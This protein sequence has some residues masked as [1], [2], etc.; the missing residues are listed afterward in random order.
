MSEPPLRYNW[1]TP[2]VISHFNS[3]TLL[4]EVDAGTSLHAALGGTIP[5]TSDAAVAWR[6]WAGATQRVAAVACVQRR[7]WIL[8]GHRERNS[9]AYSD[10]AFAA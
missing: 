2:F 10:R 3:L 4:H 7:D 9:Q 8:I 6:V 5:S 1:M